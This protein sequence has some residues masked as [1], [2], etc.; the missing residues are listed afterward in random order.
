[1][2][3]GATAFAIRVYIH[4][5]EMLADVPHALPALF[6]AIDNT[7]ADLAH[8]KAFDELAPALAKYRP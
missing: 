8:Y 2:E 6:E 5:L 7:P 4:P 3:T 1:M